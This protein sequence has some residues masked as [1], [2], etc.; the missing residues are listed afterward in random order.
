MVDRFPWGILSKRHVRLTWLLSSQ[1]VPS[2]FGNI[3]RFFRDRK[4]LLVRA[5]E[6]GN[7]TS[8]NIQH[9]YLATLT[10]ANTSSPSTKH[11]DSPAFRT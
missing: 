5:R 11:T 9:Q 7:C 10:G 3:L 1:R 4:N 8:L 6:I 2:V